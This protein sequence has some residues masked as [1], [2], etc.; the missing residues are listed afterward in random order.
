MFSSILEL[1]SLKSTMK[2]MMKLPFAEYKEGWY[3]EYDCE[4]INNTFQTDAPK[5]DCCISSI[6]TCGSSVLT[7]KV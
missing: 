1:E 7:D 5:T 3:Y 6:K 4:Y 2:L